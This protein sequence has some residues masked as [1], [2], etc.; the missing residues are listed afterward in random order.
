MR[1][2]KNRSGE[3][4][5]GSFQNGG[6]FL[7]GGV[8]YHTAGQRQSLILDS[9]GDG[10]ANGFDASPFDPAVLSLSVTASSPLTLNLGWNAAANTIYKI[11][12]TTNQTQ[13]WQLLKNYTNNAPNAGPASVLDVIPPGSPQRYYRVGYQP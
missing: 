2:Q 8:S 10:L 3:Q 12:Y 4:Q 6:Q 13:S 1:Q 11:E 9:D 7:H 5:S